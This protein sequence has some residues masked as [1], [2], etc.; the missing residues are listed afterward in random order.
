MTI[1]P[2]ANRVLL[3]QD[4]KIE[5]TAGGI[6]IPGKAQKQEPYGKVLAIGNLVTEVKVGDYVI[7]KLALA[8]LKEVDGEKDQVMVKE[9]HIL[10]VI[11]E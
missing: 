9:E 4:A 5:K 6:I 8:E 10:A 11:E 7:Y 1:K 3:Q 2:T